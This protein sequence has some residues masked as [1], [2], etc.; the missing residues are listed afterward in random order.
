MPPAWE[1]V[2][3][4]GTKEGDEELKF[5]IS[6]ARNKKHKWRSVS[7][8]AKETGL[9]K[10]RI[11]EIIEKYYKK[12]MVFQNPRNDDEWGFWSRCPEMV[13]R[14]TKSIAKKDQDSRV[15][16]CLPGS[17]KSSSDCKSNTCTKIEKW[18]WDNVG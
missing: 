12:G 8:I 10:E 16:K 4:A 15:N 1:N 5:F 7:E 2:Y 6:I 18:D 13:H 3:P 9:E 14:P 17:C 11:E